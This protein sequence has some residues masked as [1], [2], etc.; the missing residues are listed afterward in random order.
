M[1]L[2]DFGLSVCSRKEYVQDTDRAIGTVRSS[3]F[4]MRSDSDLSQPLWMA[5]EVL[6]G[7][8]LDEKAD[9]YSYGI[10]LWELFTQTEPYEDHNQYKAFVKAVCQFNE[11][12]PIPA[13]VIFIFL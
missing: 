10:V 7:Q 11:R 3:T 8:P 12:P 5:P 6:T 4:Q 1:K 2:C 13:Y 9:V